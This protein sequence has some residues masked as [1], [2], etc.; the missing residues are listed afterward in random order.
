MLHQLIIPFAARSSF[1]DVNL[2]ALDSPDPLASKEAAE[3]SC[4]VLSGDSE[5]E[6]VRQVVLVFQWHFLPSHACCG[7]VCGR[8]VTSVVRNS[9]SSGK[10]LMKTGITRLQF[11]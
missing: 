10:R 5:A 4:P 8:F 3:V 6:A 1:F 9:N 11:V 2:G 7:F